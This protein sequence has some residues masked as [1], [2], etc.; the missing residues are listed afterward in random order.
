MQPA[1]LRPAVFSLG[2]GVSAPGYNRPRTA[3]AMDI[4]DYHVEA[5]AK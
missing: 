2:A 5:R 4:D 1:A 3:D